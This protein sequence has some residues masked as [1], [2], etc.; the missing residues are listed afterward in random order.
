M[1][2]SLMH[3]IVYLLPNKFRKEK[4]LVMEGRI[5]A[6]SLPGNSNQIVLIFFKKRILISQKLN[7]NQI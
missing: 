1:M 2:N 3:M 6:R 5:I 7:L 4:P